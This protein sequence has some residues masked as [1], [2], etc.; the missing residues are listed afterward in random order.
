METAYDVQMVD[1]ENPL[2]LSAQR[3]TESLAVNVTSPYI[4]AAQAVKLWSTLP[5]TVSKTFLFTGN[6]TTTQLWPSTNMLGIGKN[7][8]A[9][10]ST[11]F[12]NYLARKFRGSALV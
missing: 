5:D 12:Q 3:L 4:A 2:Q 10:V 7:G 8:T 9:Y 11:C 6:M 1:P